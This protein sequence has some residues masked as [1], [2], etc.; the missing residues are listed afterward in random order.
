MKRNF[1]N[2]LFSG[3]LI[4]R[5]SFWLFPAIAILIIITLAAVICNSP[6]EALAPDEILAKEKWSEKEL[7]ATLARTISP[8]MTNE[9]RRDVMHHLDRQLKKLPR[10]RRDHIRQ[11]AVVTA[12]NTSLRQLRKM[13]DNDRK[14]I[15]SSMQKSAERNYAQLRSSSQKR[16]ELKK[17]MHD[18][19][20]E[21]FTREVNR[22]IFSEFTPEERVQFAPVTKVWIKTLNEMGH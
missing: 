20:V 9:H 5:K 10:E 11:Q 8:T 18:K 1:M 21:V 2:R 22:V 12:V 16:A 4:R 6:G 13:P 3:H 17:R 7:Q 19:D 15:I 14:Q